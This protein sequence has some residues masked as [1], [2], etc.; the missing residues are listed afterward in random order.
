MIK[1]EIYKKSDFEKE[2]K[3]AG[4]QL[5]FAP[6]RV[7]LIGDHTDYSGG[8]VLPAAIQFGTYLAIKL[9]KGN[10][11]VFSSKNFPEK[12]SVDFNKIISRTHT[13]VDYPL[14]VI[15]Q[16]K[17]KGLKLEGIELAYFG[18]I[19]NGA[20]LSSSASI[21]MVTA[22]ALN[23]LFSLNLS[24]V[25]LALLS[26]KAENEFIGVSSGIM[27]QFAV[28]LGEPGKAIFLN[29]HNLDYQLVNSNFKN[30]SLVVVNTNKQ[31][32]LA[33]SKYNERVG[34]LKEILDILNRKS[35]VPYLGVLTEAD[36]FQFQKYIK[37][38][39][40][41]KRFRH[42]VGE[43]ERVKKAVI[44]LKNNEL[45]K[46]GSLMFQSHESLAND[47]EVSCK[48]LDTLV[49]IAKSTEGVSGARM[50]GAGFGGCTVN[51]VQNEAI[52]NFKKRVIEE[53]PK[54]CNLEPNIFDIQLN[55]HI[56]KIF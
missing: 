39:I 50:T 55:S 12:L 14:G 49:S 52:D 44:L 45:E 24:L 6:G 8:V 42:V 4:S 13:W 7:N 3:N 19:P 29:C 16:L 51:L 18:D 38:I 17:A 26:Q 35:P 2:A 1:K 23:E 9:K 27:D 53:Y 28:G 40:L 34:E 33:G 15:A 46:F 11:I 37:D 22:F 10:I 30:H 43:N 54:I 36:F 21:E 41:L 47:Y 5:F 32:A 48:E 20:G 25:K 31:R 56:Q